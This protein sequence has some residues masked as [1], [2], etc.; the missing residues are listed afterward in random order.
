MAVCEP[1]DLSP[2]DQ[3]RYRV[4]VEWWMTLETPDDYGRTTG[5]VL[6]QIRVQVSACLST[7]PRNLD[8]A[9]HLTA[10]ALMLIACGHENI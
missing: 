5:E 2:D 9:E 10:K 7:R 6:D 8:E 1:C 4:I 3:L